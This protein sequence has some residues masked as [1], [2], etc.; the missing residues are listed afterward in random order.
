[1]RQQST[2]EHTSVVQLAT[3]VA[4]HVLLM[5]LSVVAAPSS[6]LLLAAVV[7]AS[8]SLVASVLAILVPLT[9]C[10]VASGSA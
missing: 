6:T 10:L 3:N 4:M 5:L 8:E 9:S 1:M 2:N 7:V